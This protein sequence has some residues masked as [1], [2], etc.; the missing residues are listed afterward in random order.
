MSLAYQMAKSS[1]LPCTDAPVAI[2]FGRGPASL[3]GSSNDPIVVG[4]DFPEVGVVLCLAD[5][6]EQSISRTFGFAPFELNINRLLARH[7]LKV[8]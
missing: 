6:G 5:G 7:H 4:H 3:S 2:R 8:L 1:S